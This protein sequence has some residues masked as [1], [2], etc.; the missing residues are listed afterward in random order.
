M[1]GTVLLDTGPLVAFLDGRD[2]HH[3]WVLERFAERKPPMLTCESVISEAC[4]LTRRMHD[5]H[6]SV[7]PLIRQGAVHSQFSLFE[8]L[9]AIA[10]L[11]RRYRNVP[12]SLAVGCLVR[13]SEL[14]ENCQTMTFDS[15][16]RVY[17][18]H[19]R[20]SIPLLIPPKL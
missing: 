9:D 11:M 10:Q 20:R 2:F 4:F 8:H 7:L 19:R 12:M 13:M 15:D 18:R 14:V 1:P 5:G 3:P 6:E 17:R 16:F